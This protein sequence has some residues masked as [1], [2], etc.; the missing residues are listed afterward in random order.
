MIITV[1]NQKGGVAKTTTCLN[2]AAAMAERGY[3]VLLV[4]MDPQANLT[5]SL[6]ITQAEPS[7]YEVL[8]GK[9]QAADVLVKTAIGDLLPSSIELAGAEL[10]LIHE[11]GRESVLKDRLAPLLS[12]YDVVLIDTPPSLGLLTLNALNAARGVLVPMQCHFL[13]AKGVQLL[14]STIDKVQQKLNPALG[15]LGILPTLYDKRLLLTQEVMNEM[16]ARFGDLVF[17]TVIKTSVRY[18]ESPAAGQSIL[19]YQPDSPFADSYRALAQEL[20]Q[21]TPWLQK[22]AVKA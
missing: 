16:E 6:G 18:A 8:V 17:E 12:R 2:L 13:S 1:A 7:L 19:Q 9:A 5:V 15:V 4:D 10:E 11:I 20:I 21:R 3:R 22:Q 14:L